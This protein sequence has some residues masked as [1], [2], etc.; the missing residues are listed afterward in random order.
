MLPKCEAIPTMFNCHL[1][2][3]K[4]LFYDDNLFSSERIHS[5][6]ARF[7]RKYLPKRGGN[8]PNNQ[9]IYQMAIY[10][11]MYYTKCPW[12]RPNRHK[13][14]I[15]T[16]SITT[17]SKIY[18]NLDFWFENTPSG[19]PDPFREKAMTAGQPETSDE[20]PKRFFSSFGCNCGLETIWKVV[21]R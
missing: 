16:A 19:N 2:C 21:Q 3:W 1:D 14:C 6:V 20:T 5:R 7:F 17:P 4:R 15:L 12:N 9:Q 11:C 10:L 13:I 8:I 18:P